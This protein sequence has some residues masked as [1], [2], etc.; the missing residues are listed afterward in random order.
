MGHPVYA[1]FLIICKHIY[2]IYLLLQN[3]TFHVEYFKNESQLEDSNA[4]ENLDFGIIFDENPQEKVSCIFY[5]SRP[6]LRFTDR[7][8][9]HS[10][11]K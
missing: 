2:N 5:D 10:Q 6:D 7:A 4:S 1:R 11:I 8:C 3:T 9:M